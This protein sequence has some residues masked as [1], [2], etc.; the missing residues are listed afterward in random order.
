MET[1]KKHPLRKFFLMITT[2]ISETR[3][4]KCFQFVDSIV[5]LHGMKP[6]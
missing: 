2:S 6:N 4:P 5:D 3:E 1:K